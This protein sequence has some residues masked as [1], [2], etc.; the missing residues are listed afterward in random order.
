M[1]IKKCSPPLWIYNLICTCSSRVKGT[2]WPSNCTEEVKF[3]LQTS[4][5]LIMTFLLN[6]LLI[7]L[8]CRKSNSFFF[9]GIDV[10]SSMNLEWQAKDLTAS[11]TASSVLTRSN[12]V[13]HNTACSGLFGIVAWNQCDG[14]LNRARFLVASNHLYFFAWCSLIT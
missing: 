11:I 4:H 9:L 1:G 5:S 14:R 10:W 12:A 8:F 2:N 13:F 3:D 6:P 7:Q